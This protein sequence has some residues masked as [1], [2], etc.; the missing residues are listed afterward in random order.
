MRIEIELTDQQVDQLRDSSGVVYH[1]IIGKVRAAIE[2]PE[3]TFTVSLPAD[4]VS[5]LQGQYTWRDGHSVGPH[6]AT[7][8]NRIVEAVNR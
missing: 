6:S 4:V 3:Q 2:P 1:E 7:A 5:A 8:L